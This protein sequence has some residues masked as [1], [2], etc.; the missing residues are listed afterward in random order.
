MV[1]YFLPRGHHLRKALR[2]NRVAC[3]PHVLWKSDAVQHAVQ[4][5]L[6]QAIHPII[7]IHSRTFLGRGRIT[8]RFKWWLSP[9]L[10]EVRESGDA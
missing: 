2:S 8:N 5:V 6:L 7:V 10:K 3:R 4:F 1:V 9:A